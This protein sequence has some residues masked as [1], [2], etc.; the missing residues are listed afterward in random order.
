MIKAQIDAEKVE[1]TGFNQQYAKGVDKK[2]NYARMDEL[3]RVGR[4]AFNK[5][6]LA[7]FSKNDEPKTI[8][9]K[10]FVRFEYVVIH[11]NGGTVE[12]VRHWPVVEDRGKP[13]DKAYATACTNFL[14]YAYRD[15]LG[16]ER[17]E[18]GTEMDDSDDS[19]HDPL[20]YLRE[21]YKD[22]LKSMTDEQRE[23]V[24]RGMRTK[25][26]SKESLISVNKYMTD[27]LASKQLDQGS[28]K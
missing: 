27:I 6:G 23:I 10:L 11:E 21:T 18:A 17:V 2:P 28:D 3:I 8:G 7:L 26:E 14:G 15:I 12:F 13:M 24:V 1:K 20:L 22:L 5:N 9:D 16:L 4:E 19:K 25:G